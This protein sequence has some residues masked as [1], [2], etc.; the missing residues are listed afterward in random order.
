MSCRACYAKIWVTT[1]YQGHEKE[2]ELNYAKQDSIV[3]NL[4]RACEASIDLGTRLI[5]MKKLDVP[6]QSRD[7][8]II[9]EKNQIIS[10][11]ISKQMQAMVGFRNVAVRNYQKL[12][13]AIVFSILKNHLTDFQKLIEAIR[14][15]A[16]S[17]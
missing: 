13:L 14:V 7:V 16:I 11:E 1:R 4:Q 6:Q 10:D 17:Q 8:F 15:A 5:R 9:L 12:N 2:I 3:L